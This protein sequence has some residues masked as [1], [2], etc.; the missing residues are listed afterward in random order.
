MNDVE[1]DIFKKIDY[2][3]LDIVDLMKYIAKYYGANIE[4]NEKFK[5]LDEVLKMKAKT[6]VVLVDGLGLNKV[7]SLSEKSLLKQNLKLSLRTV[8]PTSTACVLTSIYTTKYPSQH[9]TLGWWSYFRPKNLNYYSLLML[10]RKSDL[11]VLDK[12]IKINELY[13]EE[14]IFDKFDCNVNIIMNN[15]YINSDYSKVFSGSKALRAGMLD[16]NHGFTVAAR[17]LQASMR[18]FTWLYLDGLDLM[19]H[20]YGVDSYEVQNTLNEIEKGLKYIK[21]KNIEDLNII[22]IADHGQINMSKAINLNEK[23]DYTRY[24]Y[25]LPSIDTRII[26]FFVK[27]EYM[28]EFEHKFREEFSQ[29]INLY[30]TEDIEK[31]KLFGNTQY[32][33]NIKNALGEFTAIVKS[34]KFLLCDD[35]IFKELSSHIGNHSGLDISEL[36]IPLIVI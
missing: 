26:E 30:K 27:E 11:K 5:K 21:S 28:E 15:E 1:N 22:V 25:A 33:E 3:K 20:D 10:D 4:E 16:I 17:V 6:L 13:N 18:N 2:S 24:F 19:S 35:N 7:K 34:D 32:S 12:K 29:D 8:I 14:C 9:G 31:Y 23:N 36:T